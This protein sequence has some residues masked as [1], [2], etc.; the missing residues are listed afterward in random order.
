MESE[1]RGKKRAWSLSRV[2]STVVVALAGAAVVVPLVAMAVPGGPDMM[3]CRHGAPFA[4]RMLDRML[5]DVSAT[6]AQRTQIKQIAE[7]AQA[8]LKAQAEAGRALRDKGLALMAAPTL[9]AVAAESLRQQ[10]M[11]QHDQASRRMLQVMLDIGRV[12]TPEQRAKLA[13]HVKQHRGMMPPGMG[14]MGGPRS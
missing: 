8:D 14:P 9:D 2:I 11:A 7:I 4:G 5:D 1:T 6:E 3:G 12:L 13:E 10:M